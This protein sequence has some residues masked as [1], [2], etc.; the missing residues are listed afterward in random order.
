MSSQHKISVRKF[1]KIFLNQT[2]NIVEQIKITFDKLYKCEFSRV[3]IFTSGN[4]IY[5]YLMFST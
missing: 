4:G 3:K 1:I 5:I 2:K